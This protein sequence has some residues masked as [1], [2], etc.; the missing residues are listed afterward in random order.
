[1]ANRLAKVLFSNQITHQSTTGSSPSELLLRWRLRTQLDLLKP[2]MAEKVKKQQQ[3]QKARH[4][5]WTKS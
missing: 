3:D 4:D 2:N 1:M 5:Q